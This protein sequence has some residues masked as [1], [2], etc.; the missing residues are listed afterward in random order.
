MIAGLLELGFPQITDGPNTCAIPLQ[1]FMTMYL[2]NRD[3][4]EH[5]VYSLHKLLEETA[6]AKTASGVQ[7]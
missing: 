7:E 6:K 5:A 3:P 4:S 2:M 1:Y